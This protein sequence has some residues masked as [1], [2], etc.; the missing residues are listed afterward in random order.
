MD[1]PLPIARQSNNHLN[2]RYNC[3]PRLV[4]VAMAA[5]ARDGH[6]SYDSPS[7]LRHFPAYVSKFFPNVIKI[8]LLR[9]GVQIIAAV[10][11]LFQRRKPIAQHF[12][13]FFVR[14]LEIVACRS[15][16]CVAHDH[17]TL[18]CRLRCIVPC[19]RLLILGH[20]VRLQMT[21]QRT[22]YRLP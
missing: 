9:R 15:Q 6:A 22:P 5:V 10:T 13:A 21:V 1:P 19:V 12:V 16:F 2:F 17:L 7:S 14:V 4:E 11:H 18:L 3:T 8:R 20:P